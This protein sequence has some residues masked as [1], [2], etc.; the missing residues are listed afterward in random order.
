[1]YKS[2]STEREP[3]VVYRYALNSEGGAG[4]RQDSYYT[5]NSSSNHHHHHHHPHNNHTNSTG[6][7]SN[8][9]FTGSAAGFS[10]P[11]DNNIEYSRKGGCF[12]SI[13]R[14]IS[15]AVLIFVFIFF[16][17]FTIFFSTKYAYEHKPN[18]TLEDFLN[19]RAYL[20]DKRSRIP[21]HIIPKHYRLFLH[22]VFNESDTPF[23][24]SGIV[25]ITV[26]SKR[27]N[28]KRI[29]LN[30]KNLAIKLEDVTVLKSI[31]LTNLDFDEDLDWDLSEEDMLPF[32]MRRRRRRQAGND[33]VEVE[34]EV[35]PSV[36]QTGGQ[37]DDNGGEVVDGGDPVEVQETTT[38]ENKVEYYFH[39]IFPPDDFVTIKI[40][41]LEFD[42]S[43]EKMIIYLATE[44]K[45][46]IYYIVKVNFTG[47]MTN[48]KGLYFTHYEDGEGSHK[49]IAATILEP[50]NAR[51][52][53]PCMDDHNFRS[54]FEINI[55]RRTHMNTASS[56]NLEM[57]EPM[58]TDGFVVDTYNTTGMVR[59]SEIGFIITD[60]TPERYRLT[61]KVDLLA[62]TRNRYDNYM[63]EVTVEI[64]AAVM[65]V[66]EKYMKLNYP[67]E[68]I[69]YVTI[70]NADIEVRE[71]KEGMILS[72]EKRLIHDDAYFPTPEGT[73]L[74]IVSNELAKLWIHNLADYKNKEVYWLHESIPLYLEA[75]ALRNLNNNSFVMDDFLLEGKLTAMQEEINTR[76]SP[77]NVQT[78]HWEEDSHFEL[79]RFKGLTLL[80]MMNYTLGETTFDAFLREYFIQRMN[81]DS[82]DI[83]EILNSYGRHTDG[84]I[85]SFLHSWTNFEKYPIINIRR[86]NMSGNF[87]LRQRMIPFEEEIS[88]QI[89]TIPVTFIN[90]TNQ[91]LFSEKVR[92]LVDSDNLLTIET[93]CEMITNNT[94]VIVNPSGIGYYRVNYEQA[95]W[96]KLAHV[97]NANFKSLPYSTLTT[98][99]DDALNLARL[100]LLDYSVAFNVIA[101]LRKNDE[102]YQPWKSALDNLKFLYEAL[103]DHP[104]Y[105]AVEHFLEYL[106]VDKY[107]TLIRPN[108]KRDPSS[109]TEPEPSESVDIPT[110]N[111]LISTLLIEWACQLGVTACIEDQKTIF[112]EIFL[113]KTRSPFHISEED[114]FLATCTVIKYSGVNEWKL[115]KDRYLNS[116][117]INL[118]KILVRAL[119]C[120]REINLINKNLALLKDPKFNMYT[121]HILG[122]IANNKIALKYALDWLFNDWIDARTYLTLQ[123]ISILLRKIAT[124][125]EFTMYEQIF[126]KYSYTFQTMDKEILKRMRDMIMKL[127]RWKKEIGPKIY[128]DKFIFDA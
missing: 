90:D 33:T 62:Y 74:R 51:R 18:I 121:Q 99:V 3:R 89:W 26:T 20:I 27:P 128:Y 4:G 91:Q 32:R 43:N 114:L 8:F 12:V 65:N 86:N 64:F 57:V 38:Q 97:L 17:S 125:N 82:I 10:S 41:D 85:N 35:A 36:L 24:Y 110:P 1:M 70:P 47:N 117:D 75:I 92:W 66:Y 2:D 123:D 103:Q 59:A 56:M 19:H 34:E 80:R 71:I 98:L 107:E 77:L 102:L 54:P 104:S 14:G 81:N 94:W 119:G 120:S 42:E 109:T 113:E 53:Y 68:T 101:F 60:M 108:L 16:L 87:E 52:L 115:I 124:E 111:P 44:M 83:I 73:L 48:D 13:C 22:P 6:S 67:Y 100:G 76:T 46:D 72:S 30:V 23:T 61:D 69:Q 40:V 7:R 127:I 37:G 79:V 9:A 122:S 118:Q 106:V 58:E 28:N 116:E 31:R 95:H 88:E 29:E 49:F 96:T 55:A 93:S 11:E 63:K 5:S 78:N 39:P 126:F 50:N 105:G 21:K 84:T 25:W 112:R 45:Q 15:I